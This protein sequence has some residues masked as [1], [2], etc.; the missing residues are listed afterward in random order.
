M[1]RLGEAVEGGLEVCVEFTSWKTLSQQITQA[2]AKI[3]K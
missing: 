1:L 2:R 3:L